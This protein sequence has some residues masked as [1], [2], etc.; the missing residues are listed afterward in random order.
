MLLLILTACSETPAPVD[1]SPTEP[2]DTGE[3]DDTDTTEPEDTADTAQPEPAVVEITWPA[4]ETTWTL[5]SAQSLSASHSGPQD[6]T[7]TW[8]SSIDGDLGSGED[9]EVSLSEGQHTLTATIGGTG[10]ADS[11]ELTVQCTEWDL[12]TGHSTETCYAETIEIDA[13]VDTTASSIGGSSDTRLSV[14][15]SYSES[16]IRFDLSALPDE[17]EITDAAL[18]MWSASGYA[19]GGRGWT[20]IYFVEDDTWSD[21]MTWSGRPDSEK[22][23]I[24]AWFLWYDSTPADYQ[25]VLHNPAFVERLIAERDGDDALSLRLYSSGYQV[26]F[27]SSEAGNSDYHP[28]LA[29]RYVRGEVVAGAGAPTRTEPAGIVSAEEGRQWADGSHARACWDY[30]SPADAAHAYTGETGSGRYTIDPDGDG[31]AEPFDVYCDM[32]TDGGGW[33]LVD[34]DATDAD[35]IADRSPGANPDIGTTRGAMLPDY[36]WWVEPQLLCRSSHTV[37]DADWVSFDA[38]RMQDGI[39]NFALDY[40]TSEPPEY[41]YSNGFSLAERNGLSDNDRLR[42]RITTDR[43]QFRAQNDDNVVCACGDNDGSKSGVGEAG[44]GDASTCST[45]VR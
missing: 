24:G 13:A 3:V 39:E 17:V 12:W 22:E 37:A 10:A 27:Y 8:S 35:L 14:N 23:Q 4:A 7:V 25:S 11:I 38:F 40:P 28:M 31:G 15:R 20:D 26:E 43:P 19:Y 6:A 1:T 18:V 30:R 32:E 16:F 34:N 45:W 41:R 2:E 33:T 42:F 5:S 21:S 36:A 9:L 44:D 29:V